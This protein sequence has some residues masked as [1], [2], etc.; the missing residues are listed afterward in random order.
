MEVNNEK[1]VI[2]TGGS[3]FIGS[4]VAKLFVESGFNVINIDRKKREIPGVTQYPF[5]IDNKQVKGIVELIKPHAVIHIAANNSVPQSVVDPMP[6][7]TDNVLQTISLLNTCVGAGVPNFIYAS[8]SSV[9]GTSVNSDGSFKETDPTTPINPYGNTKLISENIIKDYAKVYGFNYA[10]LRLFNVA[11]SNA[12]KNGYQK[13]PL[14][15]VLPILVQAGLK[16]EKFTINGE[17]YDTP[18]GTCVR[19]YTHVNDVARAFLSTAY[20]MFDQ[21]ESITLN[22]GNSDP[23]SMKGLVGAVENALD[24]TIDVEVG[25]ARPGDMTKTFADVS[26]ASTILGWEPTNSIQ[27]IVEDEIKWQKTKIKKR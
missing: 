23:V 22:V 1:A 11:G 17:E 7:Y 27:Q 9:Y 24:T 6:T 3:G 20:W 26:E 16:E 5:E 8:S 19:D 21:N 13:D 14:V 4:N 18:D 10:N 25:D 15:H 2:I 12:G